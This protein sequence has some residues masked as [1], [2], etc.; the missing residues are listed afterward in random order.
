MYITKMIYKISDINGQT[1]WITNVSQIHASQE[2]P[3]TVPHFSHYP[4][5]TNEDGPKT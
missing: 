3:S 2:A 5:N 4:V 1:G